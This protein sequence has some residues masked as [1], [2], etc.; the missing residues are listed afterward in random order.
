MVVN[1]FFFCL[2]FHV[3]QLQHLLLGSRAK[4]NSE[5]LLNSPAPERFMAVTLNSYSI[6]ATTSFTV[7]FFSTKD[8]TWRKTER[9]GG[10]KT[11]AKRVLLW[12]NVIRSIRLNWGKLKIR[13]FYELIIGIDN[14]PEITSLLSFLQ[15]IAQDTWT[16]RVTWRSPWK[17]YTVIKSADHFWR[18]WRAR[19]GWKMQKRNR[20]CWWWLQ[21]EKNSFFLLLE[22]KMKK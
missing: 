18:C 19:E 12:S 20:L 5:G 8:F 2:L 17:I 9:E 13:T 11:T 4:T 6:P 10:R 21:S 15:N 7:Y 14:R 22:T 16:S 1:T 3:E